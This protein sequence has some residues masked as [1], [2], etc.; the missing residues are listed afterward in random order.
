MA[1]LFIRTSMMVAALSVAT[2]TLPAMAGDKLSNS[3]AIKAKNAKHEALLAAAEQNDVK[4]IKALLASGSDP[5]YVQDGDGT[6]LII[7]SANG[8]LN[9]MNLLINAGADV[10]MTSLGD[11]APLIV[12]AGNGQEAAVRL[13][14]DKGAD[15]N[16]SSPGDGNPLIKAASGNHVEIAKILLRAGASVNAIVPSDET[17]LINAAQSGHLEMVQFLVEEAKADI[18]LGV[19]ANPE[20]KPQWRSPLSEARRMKHKDVVAYLKSKGAVERRS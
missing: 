8:Y 16:V 9:A 11:G 14:L 15:V 12:A 2:A 19:I 13:L 17:A 18:S 7:A 6:A 4:A 3:F 20:H 10:N 1:H 5:N